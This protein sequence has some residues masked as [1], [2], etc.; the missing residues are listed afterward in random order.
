[1]GGKQGGKDI[2]KVKGESA[3]LIQKLF[4]LQDNEG[5]EMCSEFSD[6]GDLGQLWKKCHCGEVVR[7]VNY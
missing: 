5:G 7:E 1:M 2:I 3:E 4:L 6:L